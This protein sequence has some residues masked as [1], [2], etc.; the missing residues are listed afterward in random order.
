MTKKYLIVLVGP[1]A[2][3]K[4]KLGIEIA[5]HFGTEIIS[6]D[7]R[8]LYRELHI[9]TAAPSVGELTTVP[10]HFIKNK[11]VTDYYNASMFELDVLKCIESL[12]HGYD[13]I[14][15]VG[16]QPCILMLYAMV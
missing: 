2:V 10:H 8:Q 7:S 13:R 4:T 5:Q 14:L 11:S 1:T 12:Y 9:G 3:G 16:G 6:A 15:M